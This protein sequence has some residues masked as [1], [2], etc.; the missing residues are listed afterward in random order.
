M[1][2]F[3]ARNPVSLTE[4]P[5]SMP[6]TVFAICDIAIAETSHST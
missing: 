3:F 5:V 2:L 6:E 1:R 4:V